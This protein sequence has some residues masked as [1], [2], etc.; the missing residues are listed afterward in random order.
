M[1][2]AAFF[3]SFLALLAL[4]LLPAVAWAQAQSI[5]I[6]ENMTQP[7]RLSAPVAT[8]V[9]SRSSVA[10]VTLEN[11]RLLLLRGISAGTTNLIAL[12]DKG[13]EILSANIEV[14]M[15]PEQPK[16]YMFLHR[17]AA[18]T[19]IYDCRTTRC[20][21]TTEATDSSGSLLDQLNLLPIDLSGSVDDN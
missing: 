17:G 15:R 5:S 1:R 20:V 4:L 8:L 12:D 21:P 6:E 14:T 3:P 7:L 11:E 2:I 13:R 18:P 9:I 10:D 16:E 19:S